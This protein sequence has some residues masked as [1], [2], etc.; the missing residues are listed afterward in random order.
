MSE[1]L[2]GYLTLYES[3]DERVSTETYRLQLTKAVGFAIKDFDPNH[4]MRSVGNIKAA[5]EN[6]TAP[7]V[8]AY[9]NT[10]RARKLKPITTRELSD[11]SGIKYNTLNGYFKN[12]GKRDLPL[13]AFADI[14][15]A[16]YEFIYNPARVLGETPAEWLRN[17]EKYPQNIP[18]H[19]KRLLIV[20]SLL[21]VKREEVASHEEL[22]EQQRKGIY[23][24]CA[25]IAAIALYASL[26]NEEA[27]AWLGQAASLTFDSTKLPHE[28]GGRGVT[29]LYEE[30]NKHW[31]P[32]TVKRYQMR[33]IKVSQEEA[34]KG[35]YNKVV[36]DP[37]VITRVNF[38]NLFNWAL[39]TN[40]LWL[41][42]QLRKA[43]PEDCAATFNFEDGSFYVPPL[44]D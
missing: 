26:I 43:I 10:H 20:Q 31:E 13:D 12:D 38:M 21:G 40:N 1:K 16:C 32:E 8:S 14:V 30:L 35:T 28:W 19:Q 37:S 22:I 23:E 25:S 27:L 15:S 11:L 41:L 29:K 34:E 33:R 17:C 4:P 7:A 24:H 42:C 18:D 2:E 39:K 6:T 3:E 5:I 44:D 9:W 36:H